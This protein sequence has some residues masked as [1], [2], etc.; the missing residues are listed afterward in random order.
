[1]YTSV[2]QAV[3][4]LGT[5]SLLTKIDIKSAYRLIAVHPHDRHMLG[6]E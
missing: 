4:K 1:M 6:M 5:G 3:L 2:E